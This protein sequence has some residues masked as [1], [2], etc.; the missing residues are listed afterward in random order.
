MREFDGAADGCDFLRLGGIGCTFFFAQEIE[1]AFG[2][3]E[4][5]LDLAHDLGDGGDGAVELVGVLD[6]GLDVAD[7]DL[8][9]DRHVTANDTDCDVGEAGENGGDWESD[10]GE[11]L[12]FPTDGEEFAVFR[13]E[14]FGRGVYMRIGFD[15]ELAGVIFFDFGV[16]GAKRVLL[17]AEI[18]LRFFDDFRGDDGR[19]GDG[20]ES[21]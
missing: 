13:F 18:G 11:E 3:G 19:S 17:C 12:R 7:E 21:D 1:D 14:L 4:S 8:T 9:G 2:G 6:E 20:N 10:R 5:E 15:N 16:K